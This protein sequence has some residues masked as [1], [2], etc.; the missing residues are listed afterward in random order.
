M[1]TMILYGLSCIMQKRINLLTGYEIF[2]LHETLICF[3]D[4]L[5]DEIYAENFLSDKILAPEENF[6]YVLHRHLY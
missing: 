1:A 4:V 5:I 3:F 2:I 6:R